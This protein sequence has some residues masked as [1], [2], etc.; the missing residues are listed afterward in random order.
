MH[1]CAILGTG[2][3]Y[4]GEQAKHRRIYSDILDRI[5]NGDLMPGQ[6]LPTERELV[7][8][9]G[10]SRP[11]VAKA[12]SRLQ[13]EGIID[14]RAGS[15]SYVAEISDPEPAVESRYFGLLIPK[16]GVTEIFEPICARIAQLSRYN[17]FHLLWSDSTAHKAASTAEHFEEACVRYLDQKIDGLFF[18]P[19]ELVPECRETN[20]RIVRRLVATGVPVVLLDSDYLPYPERSPFDLVGVDNIRAGYRAAEHFL[21]Q[22]AIRVD[23]VYRPF[24]AHTV[25]SRLNGCRLA[26]AERGISMPT[27]WIHIGEPDDPDFVDRLMHSGAENLVCANDATAISLMHSLQK[28]PENVPGDVRV[29][30]FDNVKFAEYARIP[31][32]TFRQP[33]SELGEIA[34]ELMMSRLQHPDRPAVTVSANADF[35]VR[36]SS[37]VK[38]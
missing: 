21:K 10:V 33:C 38:S 13:Q 19:L 15:G 18:V 1:I 32:S 24:S 27:N 4:A 14:R 16:L 22:G 17:N 8:L 26:L 36:D 20:E 11:T 31:L 37:I 7:D 34:V 12:L 30:G 25:E 9:Y 29:I 3:I 23:F 2:M 5:Q 6:R 28:R 35:L